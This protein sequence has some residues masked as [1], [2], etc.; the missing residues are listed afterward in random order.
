VN[1][2]DW[3]AAG[4]CAAFLAQWLW[5]SWVTRQR[6]RFY[7]DLRRRRG[8]NSPAPGNKPA[9]PAGPPIYGWGA[10]QLPPPPPAPGMGREYLWDPTQMAECGGPC[11]EAQDPRLCDCGALWRD[12]A[13]KPQPHGGRIVGDDLCPPP[14]PIKPQFPPPRIIRDDFLP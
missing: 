10:R 3:F 6:E 2:A 4:M 12:V 11:W 14:P 5:M 8:S 7:D 13:R 9:P 1:A